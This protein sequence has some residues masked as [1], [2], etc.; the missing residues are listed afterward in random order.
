MIGPEEDQVRAGEASADAADAAARAGLVLRLLDG[1]DDFAACERL[2]AGIWG[3]PGATLSVDVQTALTHSGGYVGGAFRNDRLVGAGIG[4][5]GRQ[6]STDAVYLHSH[7]A[8][9]HPAEQRSGVGLAV[10]LHQRAWGLAHGL[11]ELRWTFDPMLAR[12][13]AF[14][15]GRLGALP[16]AYH[17]DFYGE[18]DDDF[19]AGDHTDR[20]VVSWALGRPLP[21]PP[22]AAA[23]EDVVVR[24]PSDYGALRRADP[25]A[26]LSRRLAVRSSFERLL[27]EGRVVT[28][29]AAAG[30]DGEGGYVFGE[31]DQAAR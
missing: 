5:L 28:R 7:V 12:N 30:D 9:V 10:K 20:V 27:G 21:P 23:I 18:L 29:W 22:R 4:W 17:R 25:A 16:T 6:S 19:N 15:L 31:V 8:G 1:P 24:V 2:L 14:N 13:A 26:G 3:S 11:A